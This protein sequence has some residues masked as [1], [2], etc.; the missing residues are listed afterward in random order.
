MLRRARP[1]AAINGAYFSK[2]TK[3]PIGDIVLKG[4]LVHKGLM[5]TALAITRDNRAIMRRVIWG[6][7]EDWT[8]YETVLACGP[9][10]VLGDEWTCARRRRDS[11]IRT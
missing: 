8:G 9:A 11:G 3:A 2:T 4:R 1:A 10:L 6:H 5:G 7:A